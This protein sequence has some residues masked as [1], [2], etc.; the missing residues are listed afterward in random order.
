M[1]SVLVIDDEEYIRDILKAAVE[2]LG[3][4]VRAACN[5]EE[6]L[7]YFNSHRFNLVITDI[8]MPVMDGIEFAK[9]IRNS[10]SPDIPII[11]VTG[12]SPILGEESSLFN[13]FITKP[14]KLKSLEKII[15]QLA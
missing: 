5:G 6:G 3:Y 8:K 9:S 12:F 11:A 14:F 4:E 2:C 13:S 15:N 1:K 10:N 7:E